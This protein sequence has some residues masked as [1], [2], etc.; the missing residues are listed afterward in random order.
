MAQ[1]ESQSH[2]IEFAAEPDLL[3]ALIRLLAWSESGADPS[4]LA[5]MEAHVAITK[6]KSKG[7]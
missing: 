7:Q 6:A 2:A 1:F 4:R 3:K 5:L